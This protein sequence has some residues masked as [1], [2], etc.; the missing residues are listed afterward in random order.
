MSAYPQLWSTFIDPSR[1]VDWTS[2]VGFSIPNYT[3]PCATQPTLATGLGSAA[4]NAA[5]VMTAL[6]S[7]DSTHNVVNIPAGT[8]YLNGITFPDHGYQVLRGAGPNSTYIYATSTYS[9]C[10]GLQPEFCLS[11]AGAAYNGS[12]AVLPPGGTQQCLWTA[13]YSQGT[14]SI[15]LSRCPAAPPLHA[16]VVLDQAD[17]TSDTN[18][19]YICNGATVDCG[20]EMPGN[21]NGRIIGGVTYSQQQVVYTTGVTSLGGGSYTVTISPGVYFSNIRSGQSPGAWWASGA[22]TAVHDGVENMTIDGTSTPSSNVA[23]FWCYQCWVKNVRSLYGPRDHVNIGISLQAVVRDS[24]FYASQSD[25]SDSYAVEAETGSGF[26]VE[27]NIFQQTTVPIIFGQ[28]AGNVIGYNFNI[29][30][31]FGNNNYMNGVYSVH[32]AGNEMNLWEGNNF[33]GM[34]ADDA[35]GA[36]DQQ[37]YFRNMVIGW[38]PGRLYSTFPIFL[39]SHNRT[40]NMVGNVLGQ[41]GYHNQYQSYATSTSAGTGAADYNTSIYS[42]GWALTG[43]SCGAPTCDPLT[44]STLMRWGNYDTVN[45]ATRWNSTEASPAAV[46]FVNAN[47]TSS[48]FSSLAQSLPASLYYSSAP[49]WWPKGKAW[50]PIGPDVSTGNVGTCSGTYSGAQGTSSSQC[51]GGTLS[52]AWASHISSIPTQDCYLNVMQ[53]RPDGSG[54]VLSFDANLCYYTEPAGPTG[55][56]VTVQ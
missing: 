7:C 28:A 6:A 8:Y 41:P 33:S 49:S 31:Q 20:Y 47:F 39:A 32:N 15:T 23:F 43:P 22:Y 11:I 45:A 1:A 51:T 42:L 4:T 50:P 34:F 55:L 29:N 3:V 40:Y 19:V 26:L 37:T 18:G 44:F 52:S 46:P 10:S 36:S 2:G 17:D 48:Y 27:N 30:N 21:Y 54:S 35:W 56:T 24:Y 38:A 16:L 53:G 9:P 14:T 13:G 25:E 5:S 12:I